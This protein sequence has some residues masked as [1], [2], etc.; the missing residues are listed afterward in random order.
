MSGLA[1]EGAQPAGH[2]S[3]DRCGNSINGN[4]RARPDGVSPVCAAPDALDPA[5]SL[6]GASGGSL[7]VAISDW[8]ELFS[9]V[10]ARL[11]STVGEW[12]AVLPETAASTAANRVRASVLECVAALH[13]LHSTVSHELARRQRVEQ[14]LIDARTALA[15]VRAE[16]ADLAHRREPLHACAP[17]AQSAQSA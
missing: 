12:L 13:Q 2:D 14:D 3:S 7:D 15:K 8:D 4:G 5:V 10:E 6:S 11:T 9:A 1:S 16:L 17:A